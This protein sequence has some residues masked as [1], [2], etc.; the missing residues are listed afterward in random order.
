LSAPA[1]LP[2]VGVHGKEIVQQ[3]ARTFPDFF[4]RGRDIFVLMSPLLI[5]DHHARAS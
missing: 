4:A 1:D 2:S 5:D 3:H